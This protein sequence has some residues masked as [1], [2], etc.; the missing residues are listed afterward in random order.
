MD[1][2]TLLVSETP[3]P[4][5]ETNAFNQTIKNN[6]TIEAGVKKKYKLTITFLNSNSDQSA[7]LNASFALSLG[8]TEKQPLSN[9]TLASLGL[10]AKDG[11]PDFNTIAETDETADGLYA[12]ENDYGTSYYFRGAVENNYVYFAGYYWRIIRIN[13]DGSLRIIYDGTIA[14]A[15]GES[16]EDRLVGTSAFNTSYNDNAYVGYMYGATGA[17]SYE[18]THSN[19]NNSTIKTYIDN[20]YKTNI[21]DKGYAEAVSD[22]IFCNDRSIDSSKGTGLGYGTNRTYYKAYNRLDTNKSPQLTCNQ[23]NDAF[24]VDDEEKGNGALTYPVGLI[25][26]DEI[27]LSGGKKGSYNSSYYLY[28]G[29]FYWSLSSYSFDYIAIVFSVYESGDLYDDGVSNINGVAP[30]INLSADYCKQLVGTGT[31]ADPYTVE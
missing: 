30:V 31:M 15:N 24:T 18:L 28:K 4:Y 14:H 27:I 8:I 29:S 23:K 10:T 7:N 26:G 13:G 16:S 12:M 11:S 19:T 1:T 22:E 3:V 2:G 6:N 17:S 20:W 25:T 9:Q 5:F 21:V